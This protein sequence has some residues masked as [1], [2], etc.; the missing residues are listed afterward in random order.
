MTLTPDRIQYLELRRPTDCLLAYQV[1]DGLEFY[2]LDALRV[3][4]VGGLPLTYRGKDVKGNPIP[5]CRVPISHQAR[6]E[7]DK[8]LHD[9]SFTGD[10][11]NTLL[12]A[13]YPIALSLEIVGAE[14]EVGRTIDC[15]WRPQAKRPPLGVV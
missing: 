11:F 5:V 12:E 14:G 13:G 2:D 7:G 3:S 6:I 4:E 15:S 8:L 10:W 1:G 9:L